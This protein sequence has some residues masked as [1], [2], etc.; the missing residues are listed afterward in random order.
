MLSY[1]GLVIKI[2]DFAQNDLNLFVVNEIII[3]KDMECK[4]NTKITNQNCSFSPICIPA[5]C[6]I[7]T[8]IP[9]IHINE[10][11]ADNCHACMYKFFVLLPAVAWIRPV[12]AICSCELRTVCIIILLMMKQMVALVPFRTMQIAVTNHFVAVL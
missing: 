10:H 5:N 8:N 2:Q 9:H 11:D 3:G 7:I 4:G 12:L 6:T 1:V